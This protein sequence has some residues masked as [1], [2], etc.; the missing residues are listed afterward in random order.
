MAFNDWDGDGKN[1]F[2]D[3]FIEYQIYKETMGEDDDDFSLGKRHNNKVENPQFITTIFSDESKKD[4]S[5][6]PSTSETNI[7]C[8]LVV[9]LCVGALLLIAFLDYD[10]DSWKG[11]LTNT[12]I[13][14]GAVALSVLILKLFGVM[15]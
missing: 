15:R 4:Y 7:A 3:D 11:I 6:P 14:G 10:G 2:A 13:L 9:G 12:G 1:T 8:W 5:N